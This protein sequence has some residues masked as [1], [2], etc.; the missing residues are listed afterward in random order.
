MFTNIHLV[1]FVYSLD[2]SF[3]LLTLRGFILLTSFYPGVNVSNTAFLRT[4]SLNWLN[5][6][7]SRMIIAVI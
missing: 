4:Q 6:K 3:Y 1:T 7:A 5:S 2:V